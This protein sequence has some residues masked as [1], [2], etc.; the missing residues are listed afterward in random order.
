MFKITLYQIQYF[1]LWNDFLAKAKNGNFL[2]HRD[3]IE[4]HSDRFQDNSL[5]IFKNQKLIALL[6]AN[7][8]ENIIYSHQGLTYGGLILDKKIRSSEVFQIFE[9]LLK[10]FKEQGIKYLFYKQSPDYQSV[11]SC[12][13][14]EIA[15][16]SFAAKLETC[17]I[18]SVIELQNDF[19]ILKQKSRIK[20]YFDKNFEIKK[21]TNFAQFWKILIQN[22]ENKHQLSPVHSLDEIQNLAQKFRSEIQLYTVVKGTEVLGG[23]LL[24]INHYSAA[25]HVQYVAST[26]E[27]R[28]RRVHDFLF[29]FLI[30]KFKKEKTSFAKPFHYFGFG[31]SDI[32]ETK[33]I[34]KGL[35][36]WKEKFGARTFTHRSFKIEI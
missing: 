16:F 24:F 29:P 7:R 1:E 18:A 12:Q 19:E 21:E 26:L 5:L 8:S 27:G 15:L 22:L 4:Y 11:I 28:K 13:A 20:N 3:F 14:I 32:R 9:S 33:S 10:Y 25:V 23:T 17:Q 6:P 36:A 30:A 2:F 31:I 35:V 34:N